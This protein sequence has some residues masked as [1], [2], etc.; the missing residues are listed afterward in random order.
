MTVDTHKT[1]MKKKEEFGKIISKHLENR[2]KKEDDYLPSEED[3]FY[4]N[5]VMN[6]CKEINDM[7]PNKES[8]QDI[9]NSE[10]TA[11][12]HVDYHSK[13]SLYCAEI[14]FKL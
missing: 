11:M 6:M 5:Y 13:F 12:G 7:M 8:L 3:S 1:L 14:F 10:T 4:P 2:G 9:L